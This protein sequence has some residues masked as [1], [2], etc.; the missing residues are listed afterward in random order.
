MIIV[1]RG[2]HTDGPYR[3]AVDGDR[4]LIPRVGLTP[5]TVA[6]QKAVGAGGVGYCSDG[7]AGARTGCCHD[8]TIWRKFALGSEISPIPP[9]KIFVA[10]DGDAFHAL[11]SMGGLTQ[12]FKSTQPPGAAAGAIG[13][14]AMWMSP[15]H[16]T[17]WL[18]GLEDHVD[19]NLANTFWRSLDGGAT[20]TN[21]TSAHPYGSY[22]YVY[23]I[24]GFDADNLWACG[25]VWN[26]SASIVM[27]WNTGTSVWNTVYNYG[28]GVRQ[29]NCLWGRAVNEMYCV[30]FNGG[31]SCL[32]RETGGGWT[33]EAGGAGSLNTVINTGHTGK[34]VTIVGDATHLYVWTYTVPA[35]VVYEVYRGTFNGTDWAVEAKSWASTSRFD[36]L[37]GRN[38]GCDETGAIWLS[39]SNVANVIEVH[40]RD[41]GTGV[42]ALHGGP[43]TDASS[44]NC[45]NLVVIDSS[46]VF[47]F[48]GSSIC[49]WNGTTWT[50]TLTADIVGF[51]DANFLR[52]SFGYIPA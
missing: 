13:F 21:M 41:P 2:T 6:G 9:A 24:F 25:D 39:M 38:I 30:T 52:A 44:N 46:N 18:G 17:V 33:A 34:P 4:I 50:E 37:K 47:V 28:A 10:T 40:R 48:G 22:G 51:A 29:V 16:Q 8:G 36:P 42:W 43:F 49:V 35:G 3:S 7:D 14:Y 15:D 20:W 31:V 32:L 27:K 12:D 1:P 23:S 5:F 19:I 26:T 45:A 11:T